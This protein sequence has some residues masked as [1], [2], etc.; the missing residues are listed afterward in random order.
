[1]KGQI[2]IRK[3]LDAIIQINIDFGKIMFEPHL[4]GR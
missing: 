3:H 1:M 4:V 2:F